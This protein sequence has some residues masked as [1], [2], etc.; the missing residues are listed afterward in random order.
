[1][2]I[3]TEI[4]STETSGFLKQNMINMSVPLSTIM[5]HFQD[6]TFMKGE[7]SDVLIDTGDYDHVKYFL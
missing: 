3:Q 7:M 1:M 2:T 6:K 4:L 5:I